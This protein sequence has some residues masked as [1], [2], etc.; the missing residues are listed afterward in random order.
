V[1]PL[2]AQHD[3]DT[4]V[5]YRIGN[6][7]YVKYAGQNTPK[8]TSVDTEEYN[9]KDFLETPNSASALQS[10][11]NYFEESFDSPNEINLSFRPGNE[12]K[13]KKFRMEYFD[14]IDRFDRRDN[15]E[16]EKSMLPKM[17][18]EVIDMIASLSDE[19]TVSDVFTG[20]VLHDTIATF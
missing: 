1:I 2:D 10:A 7:L 18:K 11:P 4:D 3:G 8:D 12:Q 19:T 17:R 9:W 6:A 13:D 20:I 15:G 5:I 16:Q 14:Y